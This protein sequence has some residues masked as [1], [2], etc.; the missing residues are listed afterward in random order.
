[1]RRRASED[2]GLFLA[3]IINIIFQS[4]WALIALICFMLNKWFNLPEA[5]WQVSLAIWFIY[6]AIITFVLSSL[7]D[8]SKQAKK[9]GA[10][11]NPY[12]S[13]NNTYF[14]LDEQDNEDFK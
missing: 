1:M 11:K 14:T 3:Y 13:S 6:P 4:E 5:F 2:N 7:I 12:S 8:G 10:N 9:S